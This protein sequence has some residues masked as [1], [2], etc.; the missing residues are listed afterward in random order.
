MQCSRTARSIGSFALACVVAMGTMTT[1]A[2]PTDQVLADLNLALQIAVQIIPAVTAVSP[3]EGAA[4]QRVSAVAT[5][6]LTVIE[7][8]YRAYEAS[9]AVTDLQ[10]LQ[11]VLDAA[12][13]NLTAEIAAAHITDP[14]VVAKVTAWANLIYSVTDAILSAIEGNGGAASVPVRAMKLSKPLPTPKALKAGWS[15]NVCKGEE[16]CSA[17]VR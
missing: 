9:K 5:G 2:C 10:K 6:I 13:A 17:L 14:A 16:A 15:G 8:D 12:K 11:A 3:V 4:I 1:T 7:S